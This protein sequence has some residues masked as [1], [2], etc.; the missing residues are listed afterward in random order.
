[1]KLCIGFAG[2][3]HA[4]GSARYVSYNSNDMTNGILPEVLNLAELL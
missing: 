2:H 1:M 3:A 4:S